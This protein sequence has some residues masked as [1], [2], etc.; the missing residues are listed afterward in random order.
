[1]TTKAEKNKNLGGNGTPDSAQGKGALP[2]HLED[3]G[4]TNRGT[5]RGDG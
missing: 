2:I 4:F 3:S 1:M 5:L